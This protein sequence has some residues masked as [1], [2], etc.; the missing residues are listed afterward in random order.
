MEKF[1]LASVSHFPTI[2]SYHR[3]FTTKKKDNVVNSQ[4]AQADMTSSCEKKRVREKCKMLI[5]CACN[6]HGF[7]LGRG[8]RPRFYPSR[9]REFIARGRTTIDDSGQNRALHCTDPEGD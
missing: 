1:V 9:I 3:I 5:I 8:D 7:E 4:I 2:L 6:R